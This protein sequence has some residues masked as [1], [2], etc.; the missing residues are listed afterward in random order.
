MTVKENP[1]V[2]PLPSSQENAKAQKKMTVLTTKISLTSNE[3]SQAI[4]LSE[5]PRNK[6][7]V[8]QF[9]N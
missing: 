1:Q 8:A 5:H 4:S 7:T 3:T 9:S 6:F 2:Q